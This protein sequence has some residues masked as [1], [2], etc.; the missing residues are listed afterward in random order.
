MCNCPLGDTR[1]NSPIKPMKMPASFFAVVFNRKKSV[2]MIT[3]Q[4][5]VSE[6][7]IPVK[8]LSSLVSATQ[9]RKAGKKLPINPD[10]RM[11]PTLLVGICLKAL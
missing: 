7:S 5:G 4:S 9:K 6:L 3:A 11:S 10:K 1:K 8:A 2:P